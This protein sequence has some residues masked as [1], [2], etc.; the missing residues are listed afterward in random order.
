MTVAQRLYESG[1]ITYMRTDSVNLSNL[2]KDSAKDH[3]VKN[4]G[5]QYS[6]SKSYK[7]KSKGAQDAHEA[8]RPTDFSMIGDNIADNDQK[9]LYQ[10]IW[11]RTIASEY[12]FK[13]PSNLTT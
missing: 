7:T 8:I 11:K 12:T 2:A 5:N 3:I 4:Y 6:S 13:N 10:L 9:R 1:L